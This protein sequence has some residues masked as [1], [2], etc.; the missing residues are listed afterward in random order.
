MKQKT[1]K[2]HNIFQAPNFPTFSKTSGLS[3]TGNLFQGLPT[4]FVTQTFSRPGVIK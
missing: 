2:Q 4:S 1:T 3:H